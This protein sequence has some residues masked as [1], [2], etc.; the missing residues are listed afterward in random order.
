MSRAIY[1]HLQERALAFARSLPSPAFY[2]NHTTLLRRSEEALRSHD[3]ILKCRAHL[4]ESQ[5][6]CAHGLCHCEAVA[7]DAGVIVL[8][9]ARDQGIEGPEAELLFVM[10]I[11][12]GLLHDIKR[13]ED[14]HALR[15]SIE[16]ERILTRIGL[17]LRERQYIADAIRNHEAFQ[18]TD[19]RED[20]AG[21]LVSDALYD[22]DKFRWGP[23]NFSVTLWLIVNSRNTPLESLHRSFHEKMRGIEKIK[24]TFRTATGRLYGPEFIDQGLVIGNAIYAEM[25]SVLQKGFPQ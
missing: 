17:G 16:S 7:R 1:Q 19:D 25:S 11:I 23:E 5:L 4:D 18:E 2:G 15:G 9:E 13:R 6:E 21:R 12:A 24:G 14:D 10:A 3:L 8:L 22:A 20:R